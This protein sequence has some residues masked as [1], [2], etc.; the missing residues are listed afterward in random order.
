LIG[1]FLL[2]GCSFPLF[3]FEPPTKGEIQQ[4]ILKNLPKGAKLIHAKQGLLQ[5]EIM[6]V[7][8]NR[9]QRLEGIAFYQKR[10][11]TEQIHVLIVEKIDD[12]E[13]K[14][15]TLVEHGSE[16]QR[17]DL[18]DLT[19][20]GR[21]ELNFSVTDP[22][23]AQ[24]VEPEEVEIPYQKEVVYDL[25]GETPHKRLEKWASEGF[26]AMDFDGDRKGELV[27]CDR[28]Y[29][30]EEMKIELYRFEKGRFRR[31]DQ[32]SEPMARTSVTYFDAGNLNRKTKGMMINFY[33][34]SGAGF[35]IYLVKKGALTAVST[36][37]MFREF[38]TFSGKSEDVNHDGILEIPILDEK[39]GLVDWYQL[40][41]NNRLQKVHETYEN[42]VYGFRIH[43]PLKWKG[44]VVASSDEPVIGK[45]EN[46][47]VMTYKDEDGPVVDTLLEVG[48]LESEFSIAESQYK[49]Q[50]IPYFI[51]ESP[52]KKKKIFVGVP[53]KAGFTT[54][55]VKKWFEWVE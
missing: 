54:E 1:I 48:M 29:T 8:L 4:T 46:Y 39:T 49:Q 2:S 35:S 17:V 33:H 7:D 32:K 15:V 37:G 3:G 13:W 40:K 22:A 27:L 43:M 19:G 12:D 44:K 36:P 42:F 20:D 26:A 30:N 45:E 25:S 31:V 38:S 52:S 28:N 18:V 34:W 23:K 41:E 51:A 24:T 10:G 9:D 47:V 16:L 50:Q 6:M 11:K 21:L 55:Q 5:K 53:R 14:K